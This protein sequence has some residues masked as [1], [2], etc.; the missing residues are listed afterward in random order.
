MCARGLAGPRL[1]IVAAPLVIAAMLIGG[2][3]VAASSAPVCVGWTGVQP[4]SPSPSFN[5]LRGVAAVS[6]CRAWAVGY[7][8]DG[9]AYHTLAERW[10]GSSW[11]QQPAPNP[12]GPA[13][14]NELL[15]AAATSTANAWAVGYYRTDTGY[16]T[17]TEHWNGTIWTQ[18]PSLSPSRSASMLRGVAA[19]S[20]ASAWAVGSYYNGTADQTLIERWNGTTWQRVPSPNPGGPA[21][22]NYLTAVAATSAASAWAVGTYS[23]GTVYQTLIEHWDGT[24]WAT[25]PSPS[26][27]PASNELAA[28]AATSTSNAWA[29]G[30][31]FNGI[32]YQTLI[33]R[34]NGTM[35]KRM[36]GPN[37]SP[38]S[39]E[40]T[41]VAAISATNAWAVGRYINGS[42]YRTLIAYWNGTTWTRQPSPDPAGPARSDAL[43]GVAATSA[44]NI[45]AVG[46]YDD[47]TAFQPLALHCC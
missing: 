11:A 6:S 23:N 32:A 46:F 44:T 21:N 2:G 1:R 42:V 22:S 39:N 4:P 24:R 17:L 40:L 27:G 7:Y 33:E 3:P 12:G 31:Y 29:V 13:R 16:R 34:W 25:V 5:Y 15:A 38:S 18:E 20:A 45:W 19:T 41:G 26:P 10:D 14:D 8:S 28:V 35:W 43:D 36:P 37:P 47:G 30:V 9:T